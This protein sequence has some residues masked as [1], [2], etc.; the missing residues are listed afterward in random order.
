MASPAMS[1]EIPKRGR[2]PLAPSAR[3]KR[4]R[5]TAKKGHDQ[6][7]NIGN[8]FDDWMAI[9]NEKSFTKHEEVA[10]FLLNTC[11]RFSEIVQDN[12]RDEQAGLTSS[13]LDSSQHLLIDCI[14]NYV[15]DA[16]GCGIIEGRAITGAERSELSSFWAKHKVEEEYASGTCKLDI[17]VPTDHTTAASTPASSD[18]VG[19]YPNHNRFDHARPAS[20]SPEENNID[21]LIC[22][23][24]SDSGDS[25]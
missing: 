14:G 2:P 24:G 10:R 7:I 17:S 1:G 16:S 3:E 15:G 9:K 13:E 25:S 5:E 18:I 23:E 12:V 21:I 20:T 19:P 4:R 22:E 11:R 8:A 6:R